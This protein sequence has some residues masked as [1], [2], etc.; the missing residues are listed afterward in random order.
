MANNIFTKHPNSIGETYREHFL[1][2]ACIGCR[3]IKA[4]FFCFVHAAFPFLFEKSGSREIRSLH[5]MISA[6]RTAPAAEAEET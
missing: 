3:L 6:H 2:A 5:E 4:A 1:A